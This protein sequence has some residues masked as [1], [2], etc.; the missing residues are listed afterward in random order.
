MSREIRC[1]VPFPVTWSASVNWRRTGGASASTLRKRERLRELRARAAAGL[2]PGR[3][4]PT[5]GLPA[6][7]LSISGGTSIATGRVRGAPAAAKGRSLTPADIERARPLAHALAREA[8]AARDRTSASDSP[9]TSVRGDDRYARLRARPAET[10]QEIV[11]QLL[12]DLPLAAGAPERDSE[13]GIPERRPERRASVPTSH[14]T[15]MMY[16]WKIERVGAE[17]FLEDLDAYRKRGWRVGSLTPSGG[18]IEAAWDVLWVADDDSNFLWGVD[19]ASIEEMAETVSELW[20]AGRRILHI[21]PLQF[22]PRAREAAFVVTWIA[23]GKYIHDAKDEVPG[24]ADAPLWGVWVLDLATGETTFHAANTTRIAVDGAA[25]A[26]DGFR[27]IWATCMAPMLLVVM[28]ADGYA[29]GW[30]LGIAAGQD[31]DYDVSDMLGSPAVAGLVPLETSNPVLPPD[32]VTNVAR[33]FGPGMGLTNGGWGL[34]LTPGVSALFSF[35]GSVI[36]SGGFASFERGRRRHLAGVA[37]PENGNIF[38]V[39]SVLSGWLRWGCECLRV[40]ALSSENRRSRC[41][42]RGRCARR[43][44]LF[45]GQR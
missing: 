21:S 40:N 44:R 33:F 6:R 3:R 12:R 5:L 26:S 23:D 10:E 32:W 27:P 14:G 4:A 36:Y 38:G 17:F 41:R 20:N 19:I 22:S 1:T 28:V 18:Q 34:A 9:D 39:L 37:T 43:T 35:T 30:F 15:G 7:T 29:P 16:N 8:I 13:D 31:K 42:T 11:A 45:C 2:Q 25:L 24:D